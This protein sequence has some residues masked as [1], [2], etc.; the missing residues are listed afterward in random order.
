MMTRTYSELIKFEAFKERFEYASLSGNVADTTFGGSRY[1]NQIFYKTKEWKDLRNLIIIRDNGCDLA[2]PNRPITGPIYIHH[3]NPI[4]KDDI[5]NRNPIIVNPE[6]LI[7]VSFDTH[8]A[9]HYGD[10]SLINDDMVVRRAND[11]CPW[12]VSK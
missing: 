6:N 3:L 7:C 9:I 10:F 2:L 12:K 5:L 4:T 11:T 1:L 8:Q